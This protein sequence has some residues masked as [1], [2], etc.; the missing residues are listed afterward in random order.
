M[1]DFVSSECLGEKMSNRKITEMFSLVRNS[2]TLSDTATISIRS[3]SPVNDVSQ[4]QSVT[5]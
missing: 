2:S 1:C 4:S 3:S 5:T